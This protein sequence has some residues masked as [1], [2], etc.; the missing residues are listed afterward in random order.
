VR[1]LR[2]GHDVLSEGAAPMSE[3]RE[4][5]QVEV[6]KE[7]A[8]AVKRFVGSVESARP[9]TRGGKAV[10]YAAYERAV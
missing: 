5:V 8:E 1:E 9:D 7:W 2:I 10:D 6:P 3:K 4:M